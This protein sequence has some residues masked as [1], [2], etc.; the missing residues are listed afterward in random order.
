MPAVQSYT[1]HWLTRPSPGFDLFSVPQPD[2]GKPSSKRTNY[3]S[4]L[5]K[6]PGPRHI[7]ARRGTE[8]F[9]AAGKEIRWADLKVL[10]QKTPQP[11][12]RATKSGEVS[13]RQ[14][15][16][17]ADFED[18]DEPLYKVWRHGIYGAVTGLVISPRGEYMAILTSHTVHI[19]ILP[20]SIH[21]AGE[22]AT[23]KLR[24][25]QLGPTAHVLEQSP[26][27]SVLWH[28]LGVM[29]RCLVTITC[30]A[31]VRL[32]DVDRENRYSCSEPTLSV[33]LKVL[34]NATSADEDMCASP[35]SRQS[36]TPDSI[37]MEVAA[38]AFG[39]TGR[40]EHE[41]GWQAMTL[42]VAMVEGD[43]YA[44]CPL[45]PNRWQ[46]PAGAPYLET[47]AAT[48]ASKATAA[49]SDEQV[50]SEQ[51]RRKTSHQHYWLEELM[52]QDPQISTDD[53]ELGPVE[54]YERPQKPGPLPRVQG[55]F[56]FKFDMTEAFN[57]HEGLSR[58]DIRLTDILV[59]SLDGGD[60]DQDV[61]D[62]S[63]EEIPSSAAVVCLATTNGKL[64][65]CLGLD[66]VEAQ[67]LPSSKKK[68]AT[69]LFDDLTELMIFETIDLLS[70]ADEDMGPTKA[71]LTQDVC[72]PYEFFVTHSLGVFSC[73]MSR[74]IRKLRQEILC[75]QE[76]AK[77]RL[78]L[79][80]EDGF[81]ETSYLVCFKRARHG[82]TDL[83]AQQIGSC[84]VLEDPELGH[85]V[86]TV[87]NGMP[88]GAVLDTTD[89]DA[90]G[91]SD[92]RQR[93][94]QSPMPLVLM[95]PSQP[96]PRSAYQPPQAFWQESA[97]GKWVRSGIPPQV[98]MQLKEGVRFSEQELGVLL[99]SH[100][101]LSP[102]TEALQSAAADLFRRCER[103][104]N[105][106][107]DQIERLD[108]Q[109]TRIERLNGDDVEADDSDRDGDD[110]CSE[111]AAEQGGDKGSQ[112]GSDGWE[113]VGTARLELRHQN[114][115]NR[116]EELKQRI[117]NL[118]ARLVRGGGRQR[119]VS[120]KERAWM[121]EIKEVAE[122]VGL[123]DEDEE[124]AATQK[125]SEQGEGG[126]FVTVTSQR[127][128]GD[129]DQNEEQAGSETRPP[130]LAQRVREARRLKDELV[131]RARAMTAAEEGEDEEGRE[132]KVEGEGR[133]EWVP[134]EVREARMAEVKRL[135]DRQDALVLSMER[136]LRELG[137]SR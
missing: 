64:H 30:N 83:S 6:L 126:S 40:A 20:E 71:S 55:P 3:I 91:L 132:G 75:P 89:D 28:P 106:F 43:V 128:D 99:D 67:W 22:P 39:G 36:Y 116:Q 72:V 111:N 73:S 130:T 110:G 134:L 82:R 31:V 105:E 42:W 137:V 29:S 7:V 45:L 123:D 94:T 127:G 11:R 133:A 19:A 135:L 95:P 115:M 65:V 80:V 18:A 97:F 12:A 88:Y 53:T 54:I 50:V 27:A 136:R 112:A 57:Q 14:S 15:D 90:V 69:Q 49:A 60:A 2:T 125:S 113:P 117:E 21:R 47:L 25:F 107:R 61:L 38:A 122:Q 44:L 85:F 129:D 84:I 93:S 102:E 79:I 33:D 24:T 46:W 70:Y 56:E 118:R 32:W 92:P 23:F 10:Q 9:V 77:L 98:A 74:W 37:E 104:V 26:I 76:G 121:R 103:L 68:H 66:G 108:E 17:G 62:D 16:F 120:A 131:A 109:A 35:Y 87:A 58:E 114:A 119:P 51:D 81:T 1:P 48:V 4:T 8:V 52:K 86:L 63:V 78:D 101:T 13:A 124:E 59:F 34:A 100:R 96:E 5:A 41:S